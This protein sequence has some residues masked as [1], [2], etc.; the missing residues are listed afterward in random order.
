MMYKKK[1]YTGKRKTTDVG[2]DNVTKL[3][4]A[5]PSTEQIYDLRR[6]QQ[7]FRQLYKDKDE[8]LS[9]QHF[10]NVGLEV[11]KD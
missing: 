11:Q 6:L 7:H 2:T 1:V 10:F 8:L 3:E 4:E 9:M 5:E